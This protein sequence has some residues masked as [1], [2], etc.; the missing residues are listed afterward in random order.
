MNRSAWAYCRVSTTK[1]EQELSLE[2]QE[3]WARG[4]AAQEGLELT[5]YRERASAKRTIGRKEFQRMMSELADL[6]PARRPAQLLVTSFDRLSRDMTDTLLIARQLKEL[7]VQLYIRDAG[8]VVKSETFAERAALVGQSMGGEAENEA[9][10]NR[11]RASWERRRREGKPTCNK[12][13]YG[14]QMRGERDV[15]SPQ[16]GPWVK[17]AF[18]WYA[19]GIGTYTIAER[20]KAAPPHTTLGSRVGPDGKPVQHVRHPVWEASRIKKML[21]QTRYRG[22]LV[23]PELFDRV[24]A[25]L[26]SKPRW[27]NDRKREY[28]LSGAIKCAGCGRCFHGSGTGRIRTKRLADGTLQHYAAEPA[29]YYSCV[30]CNYRINAKWLESQFR[31]QIDHLVA[32]PEDLR[33]WV[34][35]TPYGSSKRELEREIARLERECSDELLEKTQQRVWQLALDAKIDSADLGRQLQ[36]LKDDFANRRSQL[37]ELQQQVN[38]QT[39]ATRTVQRAQELLR[40]FWALYDAAS[41]E[42]RR[43]LIAAVVQALGGA[44]A[45]KEGITWDRQPRLGRS[46]ARAS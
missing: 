24:N 12:A 5:I 29:R 28:P 36:R 10:S 40:D 33:R 32:R 44:K 9:R 13:P 20:M 42:D 7:R 23:D 14:L 18:R 6:P 31:S 45:T 25:L 37:T 35:S 34:Q 43:E 26:A 17:K 11:Q 1:D 22:T 21:V 30:V 4:Y 15:P 41:Y 16:C 46:P 2:Q 39:T 19:A 38:T 3:A 27:R 8:G